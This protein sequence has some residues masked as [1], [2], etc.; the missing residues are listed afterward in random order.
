MDWHLKRTSSTGSERL[1]REAGISL[2]LARL[3]VLRG[4]LNAE[5]ATR[6]LEPKLAH[7]HPPERMRDLGEAVERIRR[8]VRRQEKVLVYGDY[9]VDGVTA[10]GLL[11]SVLRGLGAQAN[12]FVPNRLRDGYGVRTERIE[13]A[14][15]RGYQL[16]ITVDTGTRDF[17]P[18]E[19]A[20]QRGLDTIVVDHHLPGESLPPA[21]AVLNPH[22]KECGYPEKNLTAVGVAFKLVQALLVGQETDLKGE[23]FL[24]WVMIG[25]IADCAPLTGENRVI[26]CYGLKALRESRHPGLR[27]LLRVSDLEGKDFGVGEIAFRVAPRINAAGRMNTARDALDLLLTSDPG[28]AQELAGKLNRLNA[29]RQGT[30]EKILEEAVRQAEEMREGAGQSALVVAA[31]GW[32]RGVIGI[33]AQRLVERF[34]QPAFVISVEG[35][36]GYGSGRTVA[37]FLL[38]AALD[39]MGPL[40]VKYGGHEQAAGL[41]ILRENIDRFRERLNEEAAQ[42]AEVCRRASRSLPVDCELRFS[43]MDSNLWS[44]LK[45]LEP[46]GIG[47][48][49][50]TFSAREL[51]LLA[52][53]RILKERHLKIQLGQDG[54]T[55]EALGWRMAGRA[56]ELQ[57]GSRMDLAF[58]VEENLFRNIRSL[59]L[60]IQDIVV[61]KAVQQGFWRS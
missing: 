6:F 29:Q 33:V 25:T 36:V 52:P 57:P 2:R 14:A 1:A 47:N 39:R 8:A 44:E 58:R 19:A 3:L 17:E 38:V 30:E 21:V 13:E 56:E 28:R 26:A 27:Q 32:H 22:R 42:R 59:Q 51:T 4:I 31:E 15:G 60:N 45:R 50:P 24:A 5:A 49:K 18:L 37:G 48:P 23:R 16:L 10:S 9:D 11:L 40:F 61:K 43:E 54:T 53:P 12:C 46:C 35:D 34:G 20:R 41:T 7:L 55:M